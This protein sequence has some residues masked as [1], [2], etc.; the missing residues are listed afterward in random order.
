M[1][2]V[3]LCYDYQHNNYNISL[4]LYMSVY[5][6]ISRFFQSMDVVYRLTFYLTRLEKSGSVKQTQA[7]RPTRHT[8]TPAGTSQ[9]DPLLYPLHNV[10]SK[11]TT[12]RKKRCCRHG[13]YNAQIKMSLFQGCPLVVQ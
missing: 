13:V 3:S 5:V 8:D 10:I 7:L 9:Q 2:A 1:I 4:N 12:L 11:K 6:H